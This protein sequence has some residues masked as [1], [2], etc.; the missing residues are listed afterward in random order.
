MP[1]LFTAIG[2][3]A[4]ISKRLEMIRGKLIGARWI[5]P[6][7]FHITLCYFGEV[8]RSLAAE[9]D[10]WLRKT[11]RPAFDVEIDEIGVFGNTKPRAI[12]ARIKLSQDLSRLQQEQERMISRLLS[13]R[14]GS[15]AER[16][17]YT[18]HVTLAR[19]NR[20]KPKDIARFLAQ[21][22]GV[23]DM[24]FKVDEFGLW[25]S[26]PSVGGGPYVREAAYRLAQGMDRDDV[27]SPSGSDLDFVA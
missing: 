5:H 16:R 23:I 8:E 2:I 21:N 25:S 24:K 4:N 26:K 10:E 11:D 9:L 13:S 22:A 15:N 27:E 14:G 7:N 3:P 20:S 18:P 19:L 17:K 1:R 6:D 12:I